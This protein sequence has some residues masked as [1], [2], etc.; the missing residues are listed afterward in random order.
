[1]WASSSSGWHG[2]D[3]TIDSAQCDWTDNISNDI[4]AHEEL[5]CS[6]LINASKQKHIFH[7]I[8]S[9]CM[10]T[11]LSNFKDCLSSAQKCHS[12][13]QTMF[14]PYLVNVTILRT[15]SFIPLA[16]EN[17]SVSTKSFC[18]IVGVTIL[19]FYFDILIRYHNQEFSDTMTQGWLYRLGD[20][21]GPGTIREKW[22]IQFFSCEER[23]AL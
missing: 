13:I 15:G 1:M 11:T 9:P 2:F 17:S 23:R 4:P 22:F 20:D 7:Y 10:R 3:V 18:V 19:W 12:I 5:F 16:S 8:L 6:A 14:K 21:G